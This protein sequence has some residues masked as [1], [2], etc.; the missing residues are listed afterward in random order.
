[1]LDHLSCLSFRDPAKVMGYHGR[2]CK[3]RDSID[4]ADDNLT[5]LETSDNPNAKITRHAAKNRSCC[6]G[7]VLVQSNIVD[8]VTNEGSLF[9]IPQKITR[10]LCRAILEIPGCQ[11]N[12]LRPF[13]DAEKLFR[14]PKNFSGRQ[15][16]IWHPEKILTWEVSNWL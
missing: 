1:M 16:K 7:A 6:V 15:K 4:Y 8:L 10:L 13:R 2:Y 3:P 11:S 12:K 9:G 14:T 5:H